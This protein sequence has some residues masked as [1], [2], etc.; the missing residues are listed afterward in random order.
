MKPTVL[1]IH[2]FPLDH[3]IWDHQVKALEPVC[4]VVA[5]DLRGFGGSTGPPGLW[6][7]EDFARDLL[8]LMDG[9]GVDRFVPVGHSMGGYILFAIHRIAPRRLAGAALVA[10]RPTAD[11]PEMRGKRGESAASVLERGVSVMEESMMPRLFAPDVPHPIAEKVR[12]AIRR[13]S[14]LGVAAALRGIAARPDATPQLARFDFPTLVVS[15]QQDAIV[16][17]GEA[18]AMARAIPAAKLVCCRRSGHMPMVEE[19]EI[20]SNSLVELAC[21]LS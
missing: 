10:S 11:T 2:G 15:G 6:T 13:A 5:P 18:E 1:L 17:A 16:P 20:V 7:M 3:A 21:S 14:P 12:S 8:R 19:P 4:R 9:L